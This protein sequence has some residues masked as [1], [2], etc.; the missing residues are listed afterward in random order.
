MK[1]IH[2][3]GE[4]KWGMPLFLPFEMAKKWV[5]AELSVEEYKRILDFEMPSEAMEYWPVFTI[6]GK[7]PR[8][9]N[10]MKDEKYEWEKLPVLAVE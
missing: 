3:G 5:E 4:N 7:K 1:M 9:D 10:K 8:A 6:R 2:N